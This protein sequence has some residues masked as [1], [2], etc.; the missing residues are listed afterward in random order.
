M[1]VVCGPILA[2]RGIAV[3][4]G[5]FVGFGGSAV[6]R[7]LLI[8]EIRRNFAVCFCLIYWVN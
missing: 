3:R 6:K 5:I 2:I 1:L 7:V 8:D 4:P